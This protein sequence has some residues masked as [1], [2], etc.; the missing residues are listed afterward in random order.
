MP[1]SPDH[2][3]A[4]KG[5]IERCLLRV[6]HD[7]GRSRDRSTAVISGNCPV[8]P[9]LSRI[10]EFVELPQGLYGSPRASA[11]A[12]LDRRYSSDALIVADLSN[13]AICRGATRDIW[14]TGDWHSD[15]PFRR[16]HGFRAAA[17][18][19]Y[20]NV[21]LHRRRSY[22]IEVLH[23]A[24]Q[25]KQVCLVKGP[26]SQRAFAQLAALETVQR[27]SGTIYKCPPGQHDDLGISWA[28]LVWA[29]QHPH[30]GEWVRLIA[31]ARRPRRSPQ[32]AC[33]WGAFV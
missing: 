18:Q 24:M 19:E 5:N 20:R 2:A 4:F 33:G 13:D 17:R 1:Q 14:S 3:F 21:G 6:A 7:V 8:P 30:L 12:A 16:W 9:R 11:L 27:D 23:T 29:T 15:Y 10:R 25:A 22:L 31:V 28:M 26:E 32:N